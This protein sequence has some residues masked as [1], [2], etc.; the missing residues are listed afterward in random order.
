MSG[1]ESIVGSNVGTINFTVSSGIAGTIAS[2]FSSQLLNSLNAGHLTDAKVTAPGGTATVPAVPGGESGLLVINDT[3]PG[4]ATFDIP[5]GYNY[6]LNESGVPIQINTNAA[7]PFT[8]VI[9]PA[10]FTGDD[11]PAAAT[12]FGTGAS[13][14]DVAVNGN[15]MFV[16]AASGG[17]QWFVS[18]GAGDDTVWTNSGNDVISAGAGNNLIGLGGGNNFV[19]SGG[20]D[21]IIAGAGNNSIVAGNGT[22]ALVFGSSGQ[23]VFVGGVGSS[24]TVVGG[25]GNETLFGG[26]LGQGTF[27]VGSGSFLLDAGSSSD[28]VIAGAGSSSVVALAESGGSL[29]LFSPVAHNT[30]LAG[31]GNET[32]NAA[33]GTAGNDLF[34]GSGSASMV[35]GAGPDVFAFVKSLTAGGGGSDTIAGWTNNDS[36]AVLGY[37]GGGIVSQTSV[38]G[39]ALITLNDG[40]KI[41]VE[42]VSNVP[43]SH[44]FVG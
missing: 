29:T 28:T 6:V 26:S 21:T 38:N 7:T 4:A 2:V 30:L 11:P 35:G 41:T 27:F 37:G 32:L 8:F 34:A 10:S 15:N 22:S 14:A 43:V 17:S 36:L 12:V 13:G 24:A 33:G 16:G 3:T 44:I 23:L 42:G 5:G 31:A 40:T 20:S 9:T 25:S 1:T 19:L 18:F 39:S